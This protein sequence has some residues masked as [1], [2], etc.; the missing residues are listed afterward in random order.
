MSPFETAA[1]VALLQDPAQAPPP[2]KDKVE[3]KN[4]DVLFGTVSGPTAG[5]LEIDHPTLGKISVPEDDVKSFG[6]V[7]PPEVTE[8]ESPWTCY[9][10]LQFAGQYT[11]N[12]NFNLRASAGAAWKQ[13]HGSFTI[14]AEYF[15]NVSNAETLDNNLLVTAIEK[16]DLGDKGWF[17]FG[18]AQYEWD[19]FQ[20]WEHRLSAYLGPGYHVLKSDSVMLD[21]YAGAGASYYY[22]TD[23]W[24]AEFIVGED[25][26][27]KIDERQKITVNSS[28]APQFDDLADYRIEGRAEW[29]CLVGDKKKGVQMLLG[30]RDIYQS[31]VEPGGTN[32]DLRIYGGLNYTF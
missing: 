23:E 25:F 19:Q 24:R 21:V 13:E 10:G 22:Q 6:P 32:N 29:S 18:R 28:I 16:L 14:D 12:D 20:E 15:Y 27:W 31:D 9:V 8:P 2:P 4:G 5:R 11:A 30:V 3:L 17:G 26:E 7:P 1:L